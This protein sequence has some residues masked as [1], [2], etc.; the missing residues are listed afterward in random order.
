[1][2]YGSLP[3]EV[4]SGRMYAGPGSGSL[5]AAAQAWDE[6][7]TELS[8]VANSVGSVIAGLAAGPWQG[9]AAASMVAAVAP[10]VAWMSS[11]AAQAEQTASQAKAA[12]AAYDVAFAATA[13]PPVIA[14]NR[15]LLATLVATNLFGQNTPAISATE[16]H[17]AEMWAQDAAAMYEYAGSSAAATTLAPFN[18]PRQITDGPANQTANQASQ[19]STGTAQSTVSQISQ[20][21]SQVPDKLSSL[22]SSSG[23]SPTLLPSDLMGF[24][25]DLVAY[26]EDAPFSPLSVA[27]FP[28]DAIGAVTGVHTDDI[29]SGWAEAALAPEAAVIP[30][31][32]ALA[33]TPFPA[34][35]AVPTVLS[36]GLGQANTIGA[37]SVP[38]AWTA[39]SP[40]IRPVAVAL[41]AGA[42]SV[43]ANTLEAGSATTFAEMGLAGMAGRAVAGTLA[44]PIRRG[45]DTVHSQ[46]AA[47]ATTTESRRSPA[48]KFAARAE[49]RTVPS[50]AS[51]G[52]SV[53]EFAADLRELAKLRDE[54][55]L[56]DTEFRE[57]KQR[58]LG[59]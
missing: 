40:A 36:A 5:L 19:T 21:F 10:H 39:V 31:A 3:P 29:V 51:S 28:L 30:E 24:G 7:A 18:S 38:P 27:S 53:T 22:A 32:A 50:R 12:A 15:S 9:P 59:R 34:A 8:S 42:G 52:G 14:A 23:T 46:P 44:G 35:T 33:G 20:A 6:L 41:P 48:D 13:P 43:A 45:H 37:L 25:A 55:L 16:T 49:D 54:G 56:T 26:F 58:L 17:Y 11:T 2:D 47:G 57:Q 1:M 4:N